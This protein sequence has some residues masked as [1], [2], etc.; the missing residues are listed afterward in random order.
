MTSESVQKDTGD[1]G[2]FFLTCNLLLPRKSLLVINMIFF[3][4]KQIEQI[5]VAEETA[6]AEIADMKHME[7]DVDQQGSANASHLMSDEIH[8]QHQ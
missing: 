4:E 1:T 3:S 7:Q 8:E 6:P 5:V 2:K